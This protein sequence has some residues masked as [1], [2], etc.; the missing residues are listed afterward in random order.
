M[1]KV[2]WFLLGVA[3]IAS[4]V[5][6]SKLNSEIPVINAELKAGEP[7]RLDG[8]KKLNKANVEVLIFMNCS[9]VIDN[10]TLKH[11][12]KLQRVTFLKSNINQIDAVLPVVEFTSLG[13][14]LPN[15]DEHFANQLPNIRNLVLI[16]NKEFVINPH[17]FRNFRSLTKLHISEATFT[18]NC[19]TKHWFR[20]LNRLDELSLSDNGI[21]C[22]SYDAFNNLKSLTKL[23]L[24]YN[25]LTVLDKKTFKRLSKLEILGLY[26]N[27]IEEFD[28]NWLDG[29][30]RHLEL[31]G[32]SW[33]SL[34]NVEASDLLR[35]LPNL[36]QVSFGHEDMPNDFKAGVFCQV[37]LQNNVTCS[38]DNVFRMSTMLSYI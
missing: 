22:I 29:Q 2:I 8:I 30:K 26:E 10:A 23:D 33:S 36:K 21:S 20:D 13:S 15:L 32:I 1:F 4:G 6:I 18:E 9:G 7:L 34:R 24:T 11:F 14:H 35:V 38:V 12:P 3:V 28:A 16:A 19:I 27:N 25:K 31:L 17:V 5:S 37:L